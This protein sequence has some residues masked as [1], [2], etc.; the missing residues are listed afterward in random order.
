MRRPLALFCMCLSAL[1]LAA[2]AKTVS[3]AGFKGAEQ[4]VAE[5]IKNLQ[6]DATAGE[7]KKICA[8]D[9]AASVVAGLGGT[10]GCEAAIKSQ[11]T[12]VDS[13][14]VSV[15][16]VKVAPSGTTATAQVKSVHEG[17]SRESTVSLVKEGGKWKVSSVGG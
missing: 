10:K 11:L 4:E 15:Q 7:Q 8:D 13:L 17:K 2:C 3:T 1:A 16:S 12:E 6:A 14:E 9:A 5:T